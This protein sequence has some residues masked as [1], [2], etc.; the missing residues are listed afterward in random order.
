M[1]QLDFEMLRYCFV[2]Y[3]ALDIKRLGIKD[4]VIKKKVYVS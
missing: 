1:F 4:Y 2:R 3:R